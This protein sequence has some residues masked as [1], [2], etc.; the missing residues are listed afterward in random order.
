M[1]RDFKDESGER[2]FEKTITVRRP[3]MELYNV[4]RMG[5]EV[6][7]A[8]K[9]LL[10]RADDPSPLTIGVDVEG[11]PAVLDAELTADVP[12]KHIAWTSRAGADLPTAGGVWFSRARQGK[13]TEVHLVLRCG[14]EGDRAAYVIA[15]SPERSAAQQLDA[16]LFKFKQRMEL[17]F[18]PT[19]QGQPVGR[20]QWNDRDEEELEKELEERSQPPG[21]RRV[22]REVTAREASE[23]GVDEAVDTI[24]SGSRRVADT[25]HDREVRP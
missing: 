3:A 10:A 17:G 20:A 1:A 9:R 12:G 18:V 13:A 21:D 4:W 7:G 5:V 14:A 23:L 6:P 16:D 11:A 24:S 8:V 25:L 22:G 2:R 15:G 19:T